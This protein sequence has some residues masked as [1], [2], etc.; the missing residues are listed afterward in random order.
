[1]YTRRSFLKSAAVGALWL[2]TAIRALGA[3]RQ[4]SGFFLLHPFIEN[5]P[6]AVFI[7]P[8]SIVDKMD[9]E[10]KLK[11][12]LTFSRSVFVPGDESGIPL[13]TSIPVKINL[14]TT[15]ADR[16]PLRDIIGTIADPYFCEGVFEGMKELGIEGRQIHIRENPRGD[17]FGPYGIIDMTRRAGVDFRTD[18]Q[19]E[20][21]NG[22]EQGRDFNWVNVLNGVFFKKI[23]QLEPINTP[24]SWMLNISKFKAH[25]MG[26]T[27]CS[28]NL[29]GMLTRPFTHL[30]ARFDDD[31]G[32]SPYLQDNALTSIAQSYE[33][34]LKENIIP[35][36]NRPGD[37]GGSWQEVWS[38]R[39]LDHLSVTPCGLNIIEGI[40]G[41][42]GDCGNIGPHPFDEDSVGDP[43][44]SPDVTARDFMS[45]YIIF[46]RDIFRTD[47][48]GHWLGGHEPGNFGYFHLAIERGLSNALD[49]RKIPVYRWEN[50]SATLSPVTDFKRTPL[51]TYYLQ[52]DY[53][54]GIEPQYHLC[55]E[56]FD[57]S[58]VD[59]IE[60]PKLPEKPEVIVLGQSRLYPSNPCASIEYR[61]PMSGFIRLEIRDDR[62]RILAVPVD[63]FRVRGA[64]MALWDTNNCPPGAY[65]Y[66]LRING[67]EQKG[68]LALRK[69]G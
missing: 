58:L 23:A 33:R 29:Q 21:G 69:P 60:E 55:D 62:G 51:L 37:N 8:T 38:H 31:M 14:K 2:S 61:L 34:H 22:M 68:T 59:G 7:M 24:G 13:S 6:E 10:T 66:R 67:F 49:P 42:D 41:R 15:G 63:G 48:V 35:R 45:N 11:A 32:L 1:M 56:P 47:I 46:G 54:G 18:F 4:A 43:V 44:S 57:Y 27:L 50:G 36:W 28:K 52:R 17:S 19:G 16:F 20:V 40:Y 3:L 9:A 53:N 39:T 64:H 26:M 25:G 5:H 12:G 30:C 65:T